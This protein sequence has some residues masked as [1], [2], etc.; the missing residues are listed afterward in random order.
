MHWDHEPDRGM[1]NARSVAQRNRLALWRAL[2]GAARWKDCFRLAT[3]ALIG[4]LVLPA[5]ETCSFRTLAGHGAAD[6]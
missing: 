4:E 5:G 2:F 3:C 1:I 6:S